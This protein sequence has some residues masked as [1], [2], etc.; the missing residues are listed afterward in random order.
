MTSA[1]G[2]NGP[3][4]DWKAWM[5]DHSEQTQRILAAITQC[6][7]VQNSFQAVA[8]DREAKRQIDQKIEKTGICG[9]N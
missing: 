9:K 8:R 3:D 5:R 1:W 4:D 7:E 6:M 2:G